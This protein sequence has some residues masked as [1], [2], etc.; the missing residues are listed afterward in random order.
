MSETVVMPLALHDHAD[1]DSLIPA[2]VGDF[3]YGI[4]AVYAWRG[5]FN[6]AT[7]TTVMPPQSVF[8]RFFG[9]LAAELEKRYS[10]VP[11]FFFAEPQ[12]VSVN[13]SYIEAV[14]TLIVEIDGQTHETGLAYVAKKRIVELSPLSLGGTFD[15]S[16]V[17]RSRDGDLGAPVSGFAVANMQDILAEKLVLLKSHLQVIL[18]DLLVATCAGAP[19][20]QSPSGALRTP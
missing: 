5:Q 17:I 1:P 15:S 2:L 19:R 13:D 14:W 6:V 20:D 4:G 12:D 9:A 18:S 10:P 8:K 16:W 11:R 3:A 7:F